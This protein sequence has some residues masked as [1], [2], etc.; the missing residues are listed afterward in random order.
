MKRFFLAASLLFLSAFASR[1]VPAYPGKISLKTPEGVTVSV[2][3]HGDEFCHWATDQYGREVSISTDGT[4][5]PL[6]A[7][8]SMSKGGNPSI[9]RVYNPKPGA[10]TQ[11]KKH[12]LVILVEFADTYFTLDNPQ[13]RFT[14]Q[15]NDDSYSDFGGTGSVHKYYYDQSSGDFDPVF[16]VIGPIRVSGAMAQYGG[17]DANKNDKD[18]RGAFKEAVDIAHQRSMVNFSDYDTDGDGSVDN[19]FFYFAGYSEAEGAGDD[20]IWPHAS[21]FGGSYS[22]KLDG[23]YL[24]RYAC[25]SELRG[26]SGETMCGIGTFCHEFGHV[27]GLP[28]FYDTDYE[29]NGSAIALYNFSLMCGGNYNN[30]GC[31]PPNLN[32]LERNMLGWMSFPPEWN[33][34][35]H[36]TIHSIA[37]NEAWRLSSTNPDEFFLLEVRDGTGWDAYIDAAAGLVIYHVDQ[38]SNIVDGATAYSR[39]AGGRN[40]NIYADHPCFH[41]VR[42][43]TEGGSRAYVFPGTSGKTGFSGDTDPSNRDYLRGY[44]GFVLSGI[45]YAEGVVD[46]DLSFK[47]DLKIRGRVLDSSG[48]PITGVKV[49]VENSAPAHARKKIPARIMSEADA[50]FAAAIGSCLTD[51]EGNYEMTLNS[52]DYPPFTLTFSKPYFIPQSVSIECASGV[53]NRDATLL[54]VAEGD[55]GARDMQKFSTGAW[56]GIGYGEEWVNKKIDV[57]CGVVFSPEELKNTFVGTR[58]KDISFQFSATAMEE[59]SIFVDFGDERVLERV[60]SASQGKMNTFDIYD[61]NLIIPEGMYVMFGYAVKNLESSDGYPLS[62]DGSEGQEG[63]CYLALQYMNPPDAEWGYADYNLMIKATTKLDYDPFPAMGIKVITTAASYKAG[64]SFTFAFDKDSGYTPVS[65]RWYLDGTLQSEPSVVLAAGTHEVKAVCT[66]DDDSTE[67]I[68]Q[69]IEVQ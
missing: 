32:A 19:I 60:V 17:N 36:K 52:P 40:I 2:T 35:G 68:V 10:I 64:D 15:L 37:H 3:M 31:S 23:V 56:G 42:A 6:P 48:N 49:G 47:K 22:E 67:E 13:D 24:G 27:L 66:Y 59:V 25:T 39:W 29:K 51:A 18:P 9:Q 14:R 33:E 30:G 69:V 1:A 44:A 4:I 7:T 38:S 12:F 34:E 11:G 26:K 62:I 53:V 50:R 54:N 63:G 45:S 57:T 28:D 16:D 46:V 65:T 43:A 58:M 8:R 55:T 21:A 41:I 5:R 20:C 61:A